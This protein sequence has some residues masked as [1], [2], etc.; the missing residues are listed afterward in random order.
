MRDQGVTDKWKDLGGHGE[1]VA[2]H[3]PRTEASGETTGTLDL[4]LPAFRSTR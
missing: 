4:A 1:K 3:R 2:V